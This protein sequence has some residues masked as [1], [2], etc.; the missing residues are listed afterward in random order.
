MDRSCGTIRI[1]GRRGLWLIYRKKEKNL[2]TLVIDYLPR[3]LYSKSYYEEIRN[4]NK[5]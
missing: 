4:A 5:V 2:L 1:G 3:C